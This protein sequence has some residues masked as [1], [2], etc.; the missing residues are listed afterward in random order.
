LDAFPSEDNIG[1]ERSEALLPLEDNSRPIVSSVEGFD[2][3][4]PPEEDIS[5]SPSGNDRNSAVQNDGVSSLRI[6]EKCREKFNNIVHH[7]SKKSQQMYLW[8]MLNQIECTASS[9]VTGGP[10]FKNVFI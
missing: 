5:I 10:S 4:S 6:L 7:A 8:R 3:I 1:T 2:N 9:H